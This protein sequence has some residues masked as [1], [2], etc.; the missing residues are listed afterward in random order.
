MNESVRESVQD[1]TA[2]WHG[3][4]GRVFTGWKPVPLETERI[5]ETEQT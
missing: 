4:P 3:H 2:L 5:K 1:G